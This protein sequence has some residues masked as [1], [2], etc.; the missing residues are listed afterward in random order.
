MQLYH[1][2]TTQQL[3]GV[4]GVS[5]KLR[6]VQ[7]TSVAQSGQVLDHHQDFQQNTFDTVSCQANTCL[8]SA[9]TFS[10]AKLGL[11]QLCQ[12]LVG[13]ASDRPNL[14]PLSPSKETRATC[15]PAEQRVLYTLLFGQVILGGP[16]SRTKE[17]QDIQLHSDV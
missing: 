11:S 13:R 14:D 9:P 17:I 4:L 8:G 2:E 3:K 15:A 10:S 16:R 5:S 7:S 6:V 1:A 12:S